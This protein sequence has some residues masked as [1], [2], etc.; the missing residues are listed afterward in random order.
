M[1]EKNVSKYNFIGKGIAKIIL[2]DGSKGYGLEAPYH[3]II[4]SAS[5]EFIPV[6]WK[7]ELKIGGLLVA[8]IKNTIEVHKKLAPN[9]FSVKIYKGFS[10]VPLIIDKENGN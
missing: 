5:A 8:P 6:K 1:A 10:F 7:E 4:S 2:G 9:D 3:K